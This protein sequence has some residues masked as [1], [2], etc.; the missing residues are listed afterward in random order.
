MK[1]QIILA[2]LLCM[3]MLAAAQTETPKSES[4]GSVI[5]VHLSKLSVDSIPLYVV[6]GKKISPAE[7]ADIK[8]TDIE[9]LD[10]LKGEKAIEKYGADGKNGV[11]IVVTKLVNENS[12]LYFLNGKKI[13][14]AEMTNLDANSIDS[15]NVL[16]DKMAVEKYGEEGKNGVILIITKT[17]KTDK[18]NE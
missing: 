2:S 18:A 14:K 16:K 15:I 6:N 3:S 5:G 7:M 11:I 8:S 12:P 4:K 1:R 9:S 10:V 17:G 13:S